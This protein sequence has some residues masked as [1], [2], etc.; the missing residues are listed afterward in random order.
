MAVRVA[1]DSAAESPCFR[2]MEQA[3][4][5]WLEALGFCL[6][7]GGAQP[8]ADALPVVARIECDFLAPVSAP[9]QVA[10][11]VEVGRPG[12]RPRA[13]RAGVDR[14]RQRPPGG[15]A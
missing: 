13:C 2:Y 15:T 1:H 4:V 7:P 6:G 8:T 9:A 10:V 11:S 14:R 5:D 12:V 3:R